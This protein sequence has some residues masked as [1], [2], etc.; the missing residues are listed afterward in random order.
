MEEGMG[1][2]S[3]LSERES[4]FRETIRPTVVGIEEEKRLLYAQNRFNF[5][6]RPSDGGREEENEQD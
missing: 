4:V 5:A 3:R 6:R 2:V 1:P